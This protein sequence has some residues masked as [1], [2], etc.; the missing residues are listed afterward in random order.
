MPR[1]NDPIDIKAAADLRTKEGCF[2]KIVTGGGN[3]CTVLGE[4]PDF[5]IKNA[6]NL[7]DPI[8]A[9]VEKKIRVK[10]GAVAIVDAAEITTDANALAKTAVSTNVVFCKALEAGNAG[11]WIDA[12]VIPAYIKP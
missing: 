3:V 4:R 1:N 11:E 7:G 12:L 9:Q 5:V 8:E 6:P 2:G 10:I